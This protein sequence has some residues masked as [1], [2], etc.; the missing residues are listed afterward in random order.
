MSLELL[1]R[2]LHSLSSELEKS[3]KKDAA[4][5]FSERRDVI[6]NS[7][8]HSRKVRTTLKELKTCR[9]M[10]QYGDFSFTEEEILDKVVD[11]AIELYS[12]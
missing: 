6:A 10:A 11:E 8:V 9:A 3:G 2:H 4:K 1:I 5:F 7:E 12:S